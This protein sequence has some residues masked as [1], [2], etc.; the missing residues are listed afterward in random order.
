MPIIDGI[1]SQ[2]HEIPQPGTAVGNAGFPAYQQPSHQDSVYTPPNTPYTPLTPPTEPPG[3][4]TQPPPVTAPVLVGPVDDCMRS[5]TVNGAEGGIVDVYVNGV[6]RGSGI[7][8]NHECLPDLEVAA[9]TILPPLPMLFDAT[10]GATPT[11]PCPPGFYPVYP[12]A[13]IPLAVCSLKVG[14]LIQAT[15]TTTAGTSP[16]SPAVTVVSHVP[17]SVLTQHYNNGRTGWNPYETQLTVANVS[18]LRQLFTLMD[19]DLKPPHHPKP[20]DGPIYAQPLYMHHQ[21]F[22]EKGKAYNVLFI[23]TEMDTVYAFDADEPHH[24]ELG[25]MPYLWKTSLLPA[26]DVPAVPSDFDSRDWTGSPQTY[27]NIAP[28]IG[29]TGTPVIDCGCNCGC[30]CPRCSTPTM[31]VVSKSKRTFGANVTFHFYLHALDVIT[32]KERPN[33][34]IEIAGSV[35]GTSGVLPDPNP[36]QWVG[37]GDGKNVTFLP[38]W[39]LQRPGLLLL[40]GVVYVAFGAQDDANKLAYHGWIMSYD[41][42]TLQQKNIFCTSPASDPLEYNYGGGS[43]WMGGMGLASDGEA[44]YCTTGNGIYNANIGG[45]NYGNSVLKLSKELQVISWFTPSYQDTLNSNDIDL[46][47][48]GIMI[49]PGVPS[50]LVTCGKDGNVLL[51]SRDDLGGYVEISGN[52]WPP[53]PKSGS[54]AG[55]NPEALGGDQNPGPVSN[56]NAVDSILLPPGYY[57]SEDP[58]HDPGVW[59]GPAFFNGPGGQTIFYCGNGR[60]AAKNLPS[61][62]GK[63][64]ALAL[65]DGKLSVNGPPSNDSFTG[66]GGATPVVSSNQ[67]ISGTGIVWAVRRSDPSISGSMNQFGLT[68]RAFDAANLA[69][70]PNDIPAHCLFEG[71]CGSWDTLYAHYKTDNPPPQFSGYPNTSE[72][73]PNAGMAFIEPTVINGK[74]YVGCDDRITVFGL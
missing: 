70:D 57:T 59:G 29:I 8:P 64:R 41:A 36:N 34:P 61:A 33:S 15:V 37:S 74:V 53:C 49:I 69:S 67:Q 11:S 42:F 5:V 65:H 71:D 9:A 18:Q 14:D 60:G 7:V 24:G 54:T 32:G 56:P 66:E 38:Q 17:Y 40:D 43:I 72:G 48:G 50:L 21:Y 27:E 6:W 4:P 55:M 63:L 30:G 44:I 12:P 26:A 10:G 19:A 1:L 2:S 45:P 16:L 39:Q 23:A 46:G 51:L 25:G 3:P 58:G 22:P 31:Y 47:S 35:P 73:Y 68:L 13:E 52:N 20:L 28:Y 62:L